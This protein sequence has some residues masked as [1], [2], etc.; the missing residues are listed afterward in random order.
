MQNTLG[1]EEPGWW[2][3]VSDDIYFQECR[4]CKNRLGNDH[5]DAK[6]WPQCPAKSSKR[7]N[8]DSKKNQGDRQM[9]RPGPTRDRA[10]RPRMDRNY[11]EPDSD[12]ANMEEDSDD[13]V[14]EEDS[15]VI[16]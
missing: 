5:H 1:S 14:T 12:D 3:T 6:R 8:S 7:K 15:E 10:S 9:A 16:Q 11:T 4:T 13:A 2:Y